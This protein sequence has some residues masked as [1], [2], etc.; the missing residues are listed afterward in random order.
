MRE[1]EICTCPLA[2]G[3]SLLEVTIKVNRHL[4]DLD[5]GRRHQAIYEEK[6]K[7]GD[8]DIGSVA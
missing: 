5:S 6:G 7:R 4:F 2:D 8:E 1:V 3:L